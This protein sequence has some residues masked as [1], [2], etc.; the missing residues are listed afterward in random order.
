WGDSL[1]HPDESREELRKF[2]R[3][4]LPHVGSDE[5]LLTLGGIS[6][7]SLIPGT[8]C[9]FTRSYYMTPTDLPG[10]DNWQ[11]DGYGRLKIPSKRAKSVG[12]VDFAI[13]GHRAVWITSGN[14][15]K[16]S[17]K[18]ALNHKCGFRPCANP[19][20]LIEVTNQTNNLHGQ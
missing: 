2:Q 20:H 4:C 3:R 15:V 17:R 12:Y 8:G 7:I 13:L 16:D 19:G 1:P 18:Y 11:Y 10:Y 5:S 14:K 9:W 6:Q